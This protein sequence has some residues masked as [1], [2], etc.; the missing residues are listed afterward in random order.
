M[1]IQHISMYDYTCND[2]RVCS[3]YVDEDTYENMYAAY[4]R[5]DRVA[6]PEFRSVCHLDGHSGQNLK[7]V[8]THQR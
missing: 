5:K 2:M 7:H 1:T 6:V 8:F 4:R 3:V